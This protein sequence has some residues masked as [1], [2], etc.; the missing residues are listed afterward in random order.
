[1]DR[2]H[3]AAR[4][5]RDGYQ[6]YL[7]DAEALLGGSCRPSDQIPDSQPPALRVKAAAR[8][9]DTVALTVRCPA[10]PCMAG[11]RAEPRRRLRPAPALAVEDEAVTLTLPA[12][13]RRTTRLVVTVT[14]VDEAG[15][16]TR[17]EKQVTLLR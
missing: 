17:R 4:E 11:A 8:Q 3:R 13:A 7:D 6:A 14:A 1:M 16:A 2:R 9:R 5:D 12:R 10:E 15:N